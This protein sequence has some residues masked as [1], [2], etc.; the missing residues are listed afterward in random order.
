MLG[1]FRFDEAPARGVGSPPSRGRKTYEDRPP[2]LDRPSH[3]VHSLYRKEQ[4]QVAT[5][6]TAQETQNTNQAVTSYEPDPGYGRCP[7]ALLRDSTISPGAKW[8]W[9]ILEDYASPS[10]P[11]PFPGQATLAEW[12]GKSVKTI[13]RWEKELVEAGRLVVR[14]RGRGLT[15]Q[16][17]LIWPGCEHLVPDTTPATGP[18]TTPAT[19][20][21]TTP[22]T[23]PDRAPVSP[24]AE[25]VEAEP[26]EAEPVPPHSPPRGASV[27]AKKSRF[28][29]WWANHYPEK[30]GSKGEARKVFAKAMREKGWDYVV[31]CTANYSA[32]LDLF[33]DIAQVDYGIEIRPQVKG[34]PAWLR[35][36]M[37]D[38]EQPLNRGDVLVRW[39]AVL[40][41]AVGGALRADQPRRLTA[42]EMAMAADARMNGS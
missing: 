2:L 39:A 10:S 23:G 18:D 30:R 8:L 15:S 3:T 13:Q 16:Y 31:T 6:A 14:H 25:P 1:V 20:P 4:S 5:K 27:A 42:L 26:V 29:E 36:Q 7:R 17:A 24:K 12:A 35:T 34:A 11:E 38:F 21:D 9:T 40:R 19:G 32:A 33:A 22:A 37:E 41:E 28:D